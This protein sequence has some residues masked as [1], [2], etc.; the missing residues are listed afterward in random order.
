VEK[1]K[2]N[3]ADT[4]RGHDKSK[5]VRDSAD[6]VA[7]IR[8]RESKKENPLVN[9]PFAY[10]FAS[11]HGEAMLEA[12]LKRWPF[13]S[14]YLLVRIKFFDDVL[15]D[16]CKKKGIEQVVILGAGNDMRALRL[17]F[18]KGKK[19]FEVDYPDRIIYKKNILKKSLGRFPENTVYVG[20]DI[21][22]DKLITVLRSA[23]F[24][25]N[26]KAVFIMEGLIYY[27]GSAGVDHLFQGLS[28]LQ[29][30]GNFYLLDHISQD[31]SQ[32]SPDPGKSKPY[33]YPENPKNYLAQRGFKIIESVL[34]GNLTENY[35][36][37]PYR[38]RWWA[39]TCKM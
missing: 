32:K 18:L 14:D 22:K 11:S 7:I 29:S 13:F 36:G 1:P 16:F 17:P 31:M 19:I 23:G 30:P 20:S 35:F 12:A 4:I 24:R 37:K 26:E 38:E 33:P 9:D 34:L 6:V 27:L 3:T 10:L 2:R 15:R 21:K 39:I 25:L 5:R 28:H 8:H